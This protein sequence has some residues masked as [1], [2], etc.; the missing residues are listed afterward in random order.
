MSR[1]FIHSIPLTQGG[2]ERPPFMGMGARFLRCVCVLLIAALLNTSL[3]PLVHAAQRKLHAPPKAATIHEE[4]Y[5]AAALDNSTSIQALQA[6]AQALRAHWRQLRATWQQTGVDNVI[7][8]NQLEIER[9]FE[10][11]HEQHLALLRA[12][13]IP[14]RYVYGSVDI[15]VEKILNWTGTQTPEA[16]QQIMGQGGIPNTLLTRGGNI[17]AIRIEHVWVEALIQYHPG[18]GARHIPGKSQPDTWL[19]LD[20]SF[21]QY[22][23]ESG[24]ELADKVLINPEEII[25]AASQGATFGVGV[26]INYVI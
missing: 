11:R 21:K 23:E 14:A 16:A 26:F 6:Q 17:F 8:R 20:A 13:S 3:A 25:T 7:L 18:R 10:Q 12:S 4:N 22:T 5:C 24:M 15:P 1:A 2:V 19:P 9:A